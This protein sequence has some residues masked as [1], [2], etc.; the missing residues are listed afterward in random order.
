VNAVACPHC[1]FAAS[2]VDR[3][4]LT[5]TDCGGCRRTMQVCALPALDRAVGGAL[6]T[7]AAGVNEAM[8]YRCPERK[9]VG[10][11]QSCGSFTCAGCEV[12][13]FGE[14]LC[15]E[16]VHTLRE[17]KQDSRFRSRCTLHDNIALMLLLGPILLVPFYWVSVLLSPVALFLVIRHRKASRGVVP[18]G[19]IRLI[20]AGT[21]ATLLIAAGLSFVGLLVW[22]SLQA[23]ANF[24]DL[25]TPVP[26]SPTLDPP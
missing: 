10:I 7:A 18:R 16:C 15:L 4:I 6:P 2:V 13:W 14:H 1:G 17:V 24:D 22:A 21:L 5:A 23:G 9:A 25:A 3:G 19:P 26:V 20:L 11:C 8:C 12:E